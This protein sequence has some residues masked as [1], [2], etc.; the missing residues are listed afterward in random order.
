MKSVKFINAISLIV[1]LLFCNC[2]LN[3]QKIISLGVQVSPGFSSAT[4]KLPGELVDNTSKGG[5]AIDF[6]LSA[7][8]YLDKSYGLA[9]GIE[10]LNLKQI[11]S[12]KDYY[13]SFGEIDSENKSYE[14]RIWGSS[15]SESARLAMLHIPVH[16][17]YWNALNRNMALFGTIGPGF[18]VPLKRQYIGSG[19]FT[20]KGYYSEYKVLLYDLPE[21]G[22]STDV[23]VNTTEKLR[24][25][26]V[27]IDAGVSVGLAFTI[28]RYYKFIT[29]ISYIRTITGISKSTG[30]YHISNETGSFNSL[31]YNGQNNLNNVSFSIGIQK[32]ILF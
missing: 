28:N 5:L 16:F 10:L 18:S 27:V 32:D 22:F 14:R 3:A 19:T 6:G 4:G 17:F 13:T 30:T 12:G 25:P 21:Y 24:T 1:A 23:P 31:L 9:T 11:F 15:I 29:S 26:F 20:Y 8:Y 7:R 2:Y